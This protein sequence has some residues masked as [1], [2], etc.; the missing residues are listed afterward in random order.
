M[1]LSMVEPDSDGGF[2]VGI[3]NVYTFSIESAKYTADCALTCQHLVLPNC[4]GT[5]RTP[6]C[7]NF[8]K[9]LVGI[10]FLKEGGL[11]GLFCFGKY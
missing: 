9:I 4:G 1:N 6:F 11:F 8:A 2:Q 5:P 7:K 3:G 10:A